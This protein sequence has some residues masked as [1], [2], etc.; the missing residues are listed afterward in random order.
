MDHWDVFFQTEDD[1]RRAKREQLTDVLKTLPWVATVDEFQHWLYL[2]PEHTTDE[3]EAAWNRI[4]D[5]YGA[6]FADWSGLEEAKA[7]LWQKQLHIYEVPYYY[8]EYGMAQLGAIAIWKNYKEN[9]Q[10]ALEQYLDALR[11][12]YTRTIPEIYETAGI[13]FDFSTDYVRE[14]VGFVKE[15]LEK[16]K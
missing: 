5:R 6:G 15:E 14:L 4:H 9:P 12:G 16:L 7:N 2:F 1:L 10:K 11:L 13:R 8:I 3:R